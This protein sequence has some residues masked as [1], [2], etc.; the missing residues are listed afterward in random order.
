MLNTVNAPAGTNF[1]T[2]LM[3]NVGEME[4]KGV[5]FN[6]KLWQYKAKILHGK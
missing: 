5:E 2:K 6:I 1:A 4:N 3:A